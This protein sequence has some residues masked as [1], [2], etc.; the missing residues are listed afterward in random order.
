[1]WLELNDELYNLNKIRYITKK[2][3]NNENKIEYMLYFDD[4]YIL[5]DNEFERNNDFLN[6]KIALKNN[7]KYLKL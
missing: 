7:K 6:I 1:M 3:Y 4:L 5:Y 2:D